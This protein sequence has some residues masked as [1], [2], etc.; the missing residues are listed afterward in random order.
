MDAA[1]IGYILRGF[2]T[3]SL[4]PAVILIIRNFIPAAKSNR[5]IVYA[6][7]GA[8]VV[9]ASMFAAGDGGQYRDNAISAGLALTILYWSYIRDA[10]APTSK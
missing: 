2:I 6:I 1:E 10:K 5:K 7:C 8:L 9:F 4:M 3:D